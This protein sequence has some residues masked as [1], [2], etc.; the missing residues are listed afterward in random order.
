M[1]SS[2]GETQKIH[3]LAML[4]VQSAKDK[5]P[6]EIARLYD[7]ASTRIASEFEKM[8]RARHAPSQCPDD[9][10]KHR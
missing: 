7:N 8:L 5:T 3:E 1:L 4:C 10:P 2:V 9:S 6:E